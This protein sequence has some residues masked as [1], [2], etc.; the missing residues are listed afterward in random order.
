MLNPLKYIKKIVRIFRGGST[1]TEIGLAITLGMV[2]GFL[3]GFSLLTVCL[4]CALALL[5]VPVRL[6]ILSFV[7]GGALS[8]PLGAVTFLMGRAILA[9]GPAEALAR[10]LVNAPVT[11]WMDLDRYCTLGGIVAGCVLGVGT[12]LALRVPI[13]KFRKTVAALEANSDKFARYSSNVGVRLA[14]WLL[15]GKGLKKGVTYTD[16]LGKK[17]RVFRK[18]GLILAG[19][20]LVVILGLEV[21][22]AGYI[23]RSV[24]VTELERVNGA[25]VD[26]ESVDISLFHG[27]CMIRGVQVCDPDHLDRNL[28]SVGEAGIDF[29]VADL[30]SRRFVID[31]LRLVNAAT[32]SVREK[33]GVR[34]YEE[35]PLP[36]EPA[37]DPKDETR[38]IYDY[39][40]DAK[41]WKERVE[42]LYRL[43]RR[44]APE[45]SESD[46]TP[47]E[48]EPPGEEA[49]RAGYRNL[50]ASYLV[51]EHPRLL[52]RKITVGGLVINT[53]SGALK[54]DVTGADF[55]TNAELAGADPQLAFTTADGSL[56]GGVKFSSSASERPHI[57]NL[58]VRNVALSDIQKI[59]H[60]GN[61]V[62]FQ[63]GSADITIEDGRLSM[64]AVDIP[65]H[66][67][68]NDVKASCGGE[69][70]LGLDP[71][72]SREIISALSKLDTTIII[73]GA[74]RRPRV[75]LD[76][77][78]LL[79]SFSK[80]AVS[81][82]KNAL[83]NIL[84]K[85]L[86]E[87]EGEEDEEEKEGGLPFRL[88]L[89]HR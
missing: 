7:A 64:R 36:D 66:V 9:I 51:E 49:R 3:P 45:K 35:P 50:R 33:P 76:S 61:K 88:P 60:R 84:N 46:E 27:H 80:I 12:S 52:I 70:V 58:A 53:K 1:I 87:R 14:T 74:P 79:K 6:A 32:E 82:G 78:A 48:K 13:K 4:I 2:L 28:V 47:D 42:R 86:K 67:K 39:L 44:I 10:F 15:L 34:T 25:T 23:V 63:G 75:V 85:T 11:A 69:G 24:L 55:S 71:K 8:L 54:L 37:E 18:S 72:T 68:L 83:S 62:T 38:P 17:T 16:V 29:G 21:L 5:N 30:L 43:Y 65:M 19:S 89:P 57:L 31:E 56:T 22:F 40:E 81:A 26:I 73:R 41:R 59:L 20:V 77:D